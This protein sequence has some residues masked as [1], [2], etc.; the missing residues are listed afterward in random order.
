MEALAATQRTVM[1]VAQG[2]GRFNKHGNQHSL[3]LNP[4][5][6]DGNHGRPPEGSA[7]PQT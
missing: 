7:S 1:L 4:V 6:H 5:D 3:P 2:P